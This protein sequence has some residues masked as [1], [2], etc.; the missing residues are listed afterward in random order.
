MR[1]EW[2]SELQQGV[3]TSSC[4]RTHTWGQGRTL[5]RDRKKGKDGMQIESRATPVRPSPEKAHLL[6]PHQETHRLQTMSHSPSWVSVP[7]G[8]HEH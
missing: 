8:Q 6:A 2:R 1:W 4:H 5:L 7:Q 3:L